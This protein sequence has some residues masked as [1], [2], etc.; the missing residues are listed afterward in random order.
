MMKKP[1]NFI[2]ILIICLCI[3]CLSISIGFSAMSTTLSIN[4]NAKFDPVRMISVISIEQSDMVDSVETNKNHTMDTISVL[5][6]INSNKGYASYDVRITNLGEIDKEL[7]GIENEIFSNENMEYIID[8]L[9]VGKVI[10]AKETVDFKI[11]FKYKDNVISNETRLNAKLKFI[12]EDHILIPTIKNSYKLDGTCTFSGAKTNISGDCADNTDYINTKIAP[13]DEENYSK[14]FVLKFKI[15]DVDQSRFGM[16][17]RDTIFNILYEADDK[18]KGRY[19]GILLRIEG[20]K[21]QL[22]GGNGYGNANKI[23][24]NKDDL[25]DKEI[26]IIRYNDSNSIKIYYVI[27]DNEPKILADVT[28]LYSTFD[29]PL[30]FGAN[31]LIDNNSTDRHAYATLENMSFEFVDDGLTLK[32]IIGG[33]K[34]KE[35]EPTPSVEPETPTIFNAQGPCIFNNG[36]ITGDNC[37]IYS[38]TGYIDTGVKLFNSENYSKDFDLKFNIDEYTSN[39]QPA[40][41]VTLMNAFIE[42]NGARGYGILLR[43]NRD[44]LNLI[45]RD[46]QGTEKEVNFAA[47]SVSS[48]RVVR[49]NGNICY[50]INDQDLVYAIDSSKFSTP[51]DVPVTFGASIDYNGVPFRHIIGTLSNMSIKLGEL[52]STVKCGN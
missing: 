40:T 4:G 36:T 1:N 6:D 42:K 37:K 15:K 24:F 13:F 21:W 48:V 50:S 45:I 41:Q 14:N 16:G 30:T 32:E 25:I 46:G 51:F 20:N 39:K 2:F 52:P 33:K 29:T 38:S 44:N 8:G 17:K 23:L 12:Y 28:K 5:L 10:K 31:L 35:E 18:I 49:K 22:Q 9:E 7:T 47:S 26:K 3:S 34:E 19:P 11:K 27:G 43:K